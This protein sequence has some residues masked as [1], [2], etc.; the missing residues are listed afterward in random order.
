[1]QGRAG[2]FHSLGPGKRVVGRRLFW[3]RPCLPGSCRLG[4]PARGCGDAG[5]R[6]PRFGVKRRQREKSDRSISLLK[7]RTVSASD[8]CSP[9]LSEDRGIDSPAHHCATALVITLRDAKRLEVPTASFPPFSGDS[10]SDLPAASACESSFTE[11]GTR[12][13]RGSPLPAG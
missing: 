13:C 6:R 3:N 12:G 10:L 11:L 5:S 1:M 8:D 7:A 4:S 2:S 9:G